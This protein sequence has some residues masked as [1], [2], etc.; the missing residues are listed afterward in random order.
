MKQIMQGE[1]EN[2]PNV[3]ISKLRQGSKHVSCETRRWYKEYQTTK[4]NS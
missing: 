1:A 2:F 4:K 3:T